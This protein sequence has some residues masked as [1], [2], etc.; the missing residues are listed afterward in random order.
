MKNNG[1]SSSHVHQGK[2]VSCYPQIDANNQLRYVRHK[3]QIDFK[4]KKSDSHER[5]LEILEASSIVCKKYEENK[6]KEITID[7]FERNDNSQ[8][9]IVYMIKVINHRAGHLAEWSKAL[10]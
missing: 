8:T 5:N 3:S 1:E 4:S 9:A 2:T 10:V 6:R 7:N